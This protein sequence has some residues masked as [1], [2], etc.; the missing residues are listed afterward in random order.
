VAAI[1]VGVQATRVDCKTMINAYVPVL[2]KAAS[3]IGLAI[4][5]ALD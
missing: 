1:N 5:H 3:E 4:G 2:Q